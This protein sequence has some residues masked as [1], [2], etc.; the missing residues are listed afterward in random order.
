MDERRRRAVRR[1]AA[2]ALEG[3]I[4]CEELARRALECRRK[5]REAKRSAAA[6]AERYLAARA[7]L[8]AAQ[9][10]LDKERREA[11][12]ALERKREQSQC[13]AASVRS[14]REA[15]RGKEDPWDELAD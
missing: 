13:D 2:D 8:D 11:L 5:L 14:M 15:A 4:R 10:L 9:R 1:A 7:K 3:R 12:L 6:A